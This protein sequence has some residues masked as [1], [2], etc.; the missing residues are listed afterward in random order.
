MPGAVV[1]LSSLGVMQD[2][3]QFFLGKYLWQF[4]D[5]FPY[6]HVHDTRE[7]HLWIFYGVFRTFPPNVLLRC[8]HEIVCLEFGV[9]TGIIAKSRPLVISAV[10]ACTAQNPTCTQVYPELRALYGANVPDF[11]G[12][13]LRGLDGAY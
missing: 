11:R 1:K 6:S 7:N 9:H 13:F 3:M 2:L 8:P 12:R 10:L 5:I 4:A